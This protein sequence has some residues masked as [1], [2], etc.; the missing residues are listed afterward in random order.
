MHAPISLECLFLMFVLP[1]YGGGD[2]VRSG[3]GAAGHRPE[4]QRQLPARA[5]GDAAARVCHRGRA[6]GSRV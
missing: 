4:L 2:C 6:G 1:G 5:K 3:N